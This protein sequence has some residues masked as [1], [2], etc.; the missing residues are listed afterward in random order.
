MVT[1]QPAARTWEPIWLT[2]PEPPPYKLTVMAI[3][4]NTGSSGVWLWC[5]CARELSYGDDDSAV[6]LEVLNADAA[7]HLRGHGQE[8]LAAGRD[9]CQV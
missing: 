8:G 9:R 2:D 7:E 1:S 6:P 5:S 4:Y 3:H